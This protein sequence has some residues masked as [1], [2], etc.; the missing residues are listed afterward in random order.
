MLC[1]KCPLQRERYLFSLRHRPV[2]D[3]RAPHSLQSILT[4]RVSSRW[5]QL[6]PQ[7]SFPSILTRSQKSGVHGPERFPGRSHPEL[8][9]HLSST[10]LSNNSILLSRLTFFQN[11][12]THSA[13]HIEDLRT[14]SIF[15]RNIIPFVPRLTIYDLQAS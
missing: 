6:A 2:T 7:Q 1:H 9:R 8:P 10:T 14:A 11:P 15:L 12:R 13:T 3:L 5:R 4:R